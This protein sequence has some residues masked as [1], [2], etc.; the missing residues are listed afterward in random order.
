M[1][2]PCVGLRHYERGA[3]AD[4][5]GLAQRAAASSWLLLLP[6]P[7]LLLLLLLMV[8]M[9]LLMVLLWQLSSLPC[10]LLVLHTRSLLA[11]PLELSSRIGLRVAS[12]APSGLLHLSSVGPSAVTPPK[13]R[14]ARLVCARSRRLRHPWAATKCG[15][16]LL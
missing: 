14:K 12:H 13:R 3:H 8:L 6:A 9:V 16:I 15:E 5:T 7:L 4:L 2:R 11:H 10:N 1:G